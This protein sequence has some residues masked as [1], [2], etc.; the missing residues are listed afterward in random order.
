MYVQTVTDN[1]RQMEKLSS[2]I[3]W[4]S[5]KVTLHEKIGAGQSGMAFSATW[6]KKKVVVKIDPIP[7]TDVKNDQQKEIR[8]LLKWGGS[9]K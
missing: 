5:L 7:N 9:S 2:P 6:K 4:D 1:D 3:P 8:N